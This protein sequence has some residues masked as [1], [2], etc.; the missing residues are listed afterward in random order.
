MELVIPDGMIAKNRYSCAYTSTF[1][2]YTGASSYQE[3]LKAFV[4][5]AGGYDGWFAKAS[6]SASAEYKSVAQNTQTGRRVYIESYASCEAYSLEMPIFSTVELS[7]DFITAVTNAYKSNDINKW[8]PIFETFGTHV[9]TSTILGGRM[10]LVNEIKTED[11]QSMLSKGLDVK[12]AAKAEF[13]KFS[14]ELE[15]GVSENTQ[16]SSEFSSKVENKREIY[17]GGKPPI[18]GSWKDWFDYVL[19]GPVPIEI[20]VRWISE[21]FTVTNF[22]NLTQSDMLSMQ[23]RFLTG[24]EYYC[25]LIGCGAPAIDPS[26]SSNI[27]AKIAKSSEIFGERLPY[28]GANPTFDDAPFLIRVLK[29]FYVL[30][31]I[32]IRNGELIDSIQFLIGDG[33]KSVLTPLN[34]NV[35]S[36]YTTEFTLEEGEYV[37]SIRV[38]TSYYETWAELQITGLEFFTNKKTYPFGVVKS[39]KLTRTEVKT[40]EINGNLVGV[41]GQTFNYIGNRRFIISL[42]FITSSLEIKDPREDQCYSKWTYFDGSCYFR[43]EKNSTFD[44][45]KKDCE[46]RGATLAIPNTNEEFEFLKKLFVTNTQIEQYSWVWCFIL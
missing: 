3:D 21:L 26:M 38:Q 23:Q 4:K 46:S 44:A 2:E 33:K 29:P 34:G 15:I 28:P 17:L 20:S 43:V 22:K 5:I 18:N 9:V 40:I 30:K 11:F 42:G 41:Y 31:K 10:H 32:I 1:S 36:G 6:F 35:G 19:S 45:A 12:A 13:M 27:L 37:T 14:G 8:V 24:L 39:S 7:K 16:A 25:K